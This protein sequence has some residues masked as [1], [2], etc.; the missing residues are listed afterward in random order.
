MFCPAL[1]SLTRRGRGL[2]GRNGQRVE[3]LRA[4]LYGAGVTPGFRP[5]T[6]PWGTTGPAPEA[7]WTIPGSYI[8]YLQG[9]HRR[10]YLEAAPALASCG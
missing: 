7:Q 4:H 5:D 9:F 6:E 3:C 10:C 8:L 2:A 1:S